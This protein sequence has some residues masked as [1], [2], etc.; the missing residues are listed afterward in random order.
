M[1]PAEGEWIM[2]LEKLASAI[3]EQNWFTVFLEVLIVIVGIFI[4]LQVDDWNEAR[5]DRIREIEYLQRIDGELAQDI[6]AFEDGIS[7]ANTRLQDA[8][9][10]LE[11]LA[12]PAIAPRQPTRTHRMDANNNYRAGMDPNCKRGG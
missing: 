6:S 5:K 1:L 2:V 10:I 11:T 7:I 9:L 3:A 4:G 12:D 8:K